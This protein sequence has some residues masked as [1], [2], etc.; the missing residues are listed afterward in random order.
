MIEENKKDQLQ[1]SPLGD[2]A[3]GKP[4]TS[5]NAS[6]ERPEDP[7]SQ[8]EAEAKVENTEP[9]K[10]T[11]SIRTYVSDIAKLVKDGISLADIALSEQGKRFS[12]TT[13]QKIKNKEKERDR[14]NRLILFSTLI[15]IILG[16]LVMVGL[17]FIPK[18]KED[19]AEEVEIPSII[20]SNSTEEIFLKDLNRVKLLKTI[21]LRRVSVEIPLGAVVNLY[22]TTPEGESKRILGAQDFFNVIDANIKPAFSRSL[23]SE[24]ILGAHS[25]DGNQGFLLFQVESFNNAFSGIL[26]WEKTMLDDL[27]PMFYSQK[28]DVSLGDESTIGAFQK[29]FQDIIVK[30]KDARILEDKN[31]ET[32]LIYSFPDRDHLIITIEKSTLIEIF[33]RL[34]T[35]RFRN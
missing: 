29:N 28:P 32:A 34:T 30:N 33:E 19:L 20:S 4:D 23:K 8:G 5:D 31:G 22:I 2:G 21:N 12:S 35:G 11:S 27:W 6:R 14:K 24:F 3:P 1:S 7:S 17:L 26:D 18:D 15:F 16:I 10:K 13:Q 25:F 9:A